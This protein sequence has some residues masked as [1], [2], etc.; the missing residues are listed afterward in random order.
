MT[1]LRN[2]DLK[3]S[4]YSKIGGYYSKLQVL[5]RVQLLYSQISEGNYR[6]DQ[7]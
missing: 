3:A 6:P 1:I 4:V 5:E 2:Y 7:E